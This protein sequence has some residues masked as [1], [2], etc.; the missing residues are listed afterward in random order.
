MSE[1]T[2]VR[3]SEDVARRLRSHATATSQSASGLAGRLI[4][5]GLR[6]ESFPGIVFR[7]GPSGRRA[8]LA[9]GP[10]VWQ[11]IARL[12]LLPER[13]DAAIKECARWMALS[14]DEVRLALAYY[15]DF[16]DEIDARIRANEEAA[17][18]VR[19]ALEAQQRVIG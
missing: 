7:P 6:M 4:D 2:S 17:E 18:R 11:V 19:R 15:G 12:R 10:D 1:V 14:E 9:R 3:L 13:G 16:P 5:E 8:A